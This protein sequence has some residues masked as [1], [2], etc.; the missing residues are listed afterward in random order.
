MTSTASSLPLITRARSHAEREAITDHSGKY[1]YTDLLEGSARV[2]TTFLGG[3]PDLAEARVAFLV[4]PS[5]EHVA[6]QWGIWRAGGIAV[7]LAVSHPAS[8][9][10]YVIAD[11]GADIVVADADAAGKLEP[12]ARAAGARFLLVADALDAVRQGQS[13]PDVSDER[14]AMMVYTSG[15]TGKPKGVVTTHANLRAQITALIEAWGWTADDRILL[16]L[17]LHHVHGIVNVVGCALWAGA[18]CE[19]LPK[20][21]AEETWKRIAAGRLTVFS[22]VPTIYTRLIAAWEAA[23]PEQ[24]ACRKHAGGCG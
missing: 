6:V 8:E 18:A 15:T 10:E 9:L 23:S 13:M 5:F 4:S 2:A 19:M 16:V 14:R 7:P 17:P 11:A 22:A 3:R 1:T 21:D 12:L 24:R 20:F